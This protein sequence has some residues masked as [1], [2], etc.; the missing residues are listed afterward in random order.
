MRRAPNKND[1]LIIV[2]AGVFGLSTALE[3]SRRGFSNVTVLDRY[4]PPVPDGSSVDISRIIRPDY[5]DAFYAQLGLEALKGWETE[6]SDYFYRS[7]L[8]FATED[9]NSEYLEGS[10]KNLLKLGQSITLFSGNEVRQKYSGIQ[11]DLSRAH[12]YWNESSGWADAEGAIR[13]LAHQCSLAGVSFITGARGTVTSLLRDGKRVVGVQTKAQVELHCDLL[14]LATG[15]WTAQLLNMSQVSV[16]TAQPVGF[17]QLTPE[18]A[19]ELSK[20]PV[21]INF[22]T[23][24]FA[25]PPTPGTHILK[26][27]RHGYGYETPRQTPGTRGLISTPDLNKDNSVS[28]Y[29]PEEADDALRAGLALFLPKFK[30]RPF[31]RR[32][33]C[34]Y[35]DTVKGNF[36]VDDHPDYDNLFLA[37]GGSGQ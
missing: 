27:A 5:A 37:T 12:G 10:K 15:A 4:N 36:I 20:C 8:I 26:M 21:M 35:T 7:G 11:G 18:E 6:Y 24:W 19:A 3:L 28:N 16:S 9:E 29:I 2:G 23:G 32:R 14:I 22:S 34:W 33:M 13:F 1:R 31:I 25:F 30:D 17:M